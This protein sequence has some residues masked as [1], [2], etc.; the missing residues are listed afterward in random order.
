MTSGRVL[1]SP[2]VNA[3]FELFYRLPGVSEREAG[4]GLGLA[5]VKSIA[6]RHEDDV[7]SE[8]RAGWGASFNV[9]LL[10]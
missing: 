7:R 10:I 4:V 9:E 3:F 2:S 5:L 1:P 8:A 6:Q